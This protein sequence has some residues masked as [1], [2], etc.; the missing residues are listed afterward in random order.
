MVYQ[1]LE[2]V[3]A[4]YVAITGTTI[5]F[6]V[7]ESWLD[8][9]N[10]DPDDIVMYHYVNNA[11]VALPTT[12]EERTNGFVTFTATSPSFSLFAIAGMPETAEP[13]A[14]HLKTI[15]DLAGPSSSPPVA[16]TKA[17][18]VQQTTAAPTPAAEPD[19]GLP[20]MLIV[21]AL[22]GLFI[23]AGCGFLVRR[24]WIRRQNPALFEK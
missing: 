7:P 10:A 13:E 16:E 15:G 20:L 8:D 1:Y 5:T 4:Q 9:H 17:P 21:P 6:T 3:P 23:L 18:V 2:I 14:E 19:H 11:W 22:A 24:W 12:M